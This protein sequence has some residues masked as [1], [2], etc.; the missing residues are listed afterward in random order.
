MYKKL[1]ISILCLFIALS[2]VGCEITSSQVVSVAENVHFLISEDGTDIFGSIWYAGKWWSLYH[3]TS[4]G[5][6]KYGT[7]SYW[8]INRTRMLLVEA[9]YKFTNWGLLPYMVKETI[10]STMINSLPLQPVWTAPIL[11]LPIL[12]GMPELIVTEVPM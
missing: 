9:G 3:N 8:N 2:L 12:P 1:L 7:D 10:M 4:S 6:L 11:V 5:V